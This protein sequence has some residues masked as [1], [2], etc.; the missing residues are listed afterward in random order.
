[1]DNPPAAQ[2]LEDKGFHALFDLAALKLPTANVTVVVQRTYLESHRDV[3]Q[4][5]VD[6]LVQGAARARKD[7]PFTV[8][9]AKKYFKLDDDKALK[10]TYDFFIGEIAPSLPYPRPEQFADAIEVLAQKNDKVRSLDLNTVL[11]ATFVDSAAK[12]GLDKT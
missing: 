7:G 11:D 4:R 1:M 6:S 9:V 12:R 5:Y 8:S 3:A 2:E 10:D